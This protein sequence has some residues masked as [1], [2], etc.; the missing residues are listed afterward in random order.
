MILCL[1]WACEGL[2]PKLIAQGLQHGQS[3]QELRAGV[4]KHWW[5]ECSSSPAPGK[6]GPLGC[7]GPGHPLFGWLCL[8]SGRWETPHFPDSGNTVDEGVKS[9]L[10]GGTLVL[11]L[12]L[13]KSLFFFLVVFS[14]NS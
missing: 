3:V 14:A 12:S 7:W 13:S 9:L 10:S 5:Q 1:P 11:A 4:P 6:R 2:F 8:L